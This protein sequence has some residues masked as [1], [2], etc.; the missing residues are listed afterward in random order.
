MLLELRMMPR[1][2]GALPGE[3]GS[4]IQP[5]A[6]KARSALRGAR[7]LPTSLHARRFLHGSAC[8][9]WTDREQRMVP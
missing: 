3:V 6:R 7:R 4:A 9:K 5:V 1:S 8:D 2:C